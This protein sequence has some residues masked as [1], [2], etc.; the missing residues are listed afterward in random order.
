MAPATR[1]V[2]VLNEPASAF[3]RLLKA[4]A[5]ID[6]GRSGETGAERRQAPA[7]PQQLPRPRSGGASARPAAEAKTE[8]PAAEAKPEAPAG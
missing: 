4:K 3:A 7:E 5:S 1:L 6:A 8:A 2:R